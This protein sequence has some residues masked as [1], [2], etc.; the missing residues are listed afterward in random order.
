MN[1]LLN[2]VLARIYIVGVITVAGLA[3]LI[4]YALRD[5]L[6][7]VPGPWYTKWTS[8][9]IKDHWL[10]GNRASYQHSLH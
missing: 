1:D 3:F 8:V 4:F 6:S 2:V 10:K 7:K 5:P 9:V